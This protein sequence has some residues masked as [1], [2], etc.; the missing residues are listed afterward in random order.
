MTALTVLATAY[1]QIG[2]AE[3]AN[4]TRIQARRLERHLMP[5][6]WARQILRRTRVADD[7]M[8]WSEHASRALSMRPRA[9]R[10][11][12]L[13]VLDKVIQ[14]DSL[15]VASLIVS[16][17]LLGEYSKAKATQE[18]LRMVN[19]IVS[20]EKDLCERGLLERGVSK[21]LVELFDQV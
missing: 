6:V 7:A 13:E 2:N 15:S 3:R 19:R 11:H 16:L 14:E 9:A 10:L 21:D 20:L 1:H 4:A 12:Q 5:G 17:L 8:K 18:V